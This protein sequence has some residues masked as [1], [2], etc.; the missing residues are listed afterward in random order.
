[1][2]NIDKTVE[3]IYSG[4]LG[5][6]I[7]V[8]YGAPIEGWTYEQ[9]QRV[10]G[11]LTIR[12]DLYYS[13]SMEELFIADDDTSMPSV[14]LQILLDKLKNRKPKISALEFGEGWLNYIP[15]DHGVIWRGRYGLS[16]EYTAFQNLHSG[17][18]APLSGSAEL[19]GRD[20]A[21]QIGGQIFSDIWGLLFPSDPERAANWADQ[22]SSVSHDLDG[23]IG[24]QFIAAMVSTA[25]GAETIDQVVELALAVLPPDAQYTL[26]MSDIRDFWKSHPENWH[27][28]RRYIAARYG[29]D[30]YPGPVPIIPNAAVIV[31]ALLYGQGDFDRSIRIANAAGWDTD[32]N[33]GN[34]G[35]IVGTLVGPQGIPAEWRKPLADRFVGSG[36]LGARNA[37]TIPGFSR[38]IHQVS[39]VL[40][41]DQVSES[42]PGAQ[43]SASLVEFATQ[44]LTFDFPGSTEGVQIDDLFDNAVIHIEQTEERAYAGNG[45]L[46]V[47]LKDLTASKPGRIVYPTLLRPV[48]F[49]RLQYDPSFSPVLYAGQAVRVEVYLPSEHALDN[50]SA[51]VSAGLLIRTLSARHD[52][53]RSTTIYSPFVELTPGAWTALEWMIPAVEGIITDVIIE[54]RSSH[55]YVS[56]SGPVY[57]DELRWF[58]NAHL[59]M[60]F[61]DAVSAFGAIE[62]WSYCSGYWRSEK[63]AYV[64]SGAELGETYTGNP[65]WRDVQISAVLRPESGFWHLV[66]A[67]VQGCR[68]SYGLGLGPDGQIVVVK[69]LDGKREVVAYSSYRWHTGIGYRVD[70]TVNETTIEL[71]VH[72]EGNSLHFQRVLWEDTSEEPLTRG[73]VGLAVRDGSRLACLDFQVNAVH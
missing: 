28:A 5:K 21:E 64:G 36:V 49:Y 55:N 32:C 27:A 26:V 65:E 61:D 11:D 23:R 9:I 10:Y 14:M 16:T 51:Q 38:L 2:E 33:T 6:V 25:F 1:M 18:P 39:Q 48:H 62:G 72:E 31:M 41:S 37:W 35:A 40:S 59:K 71:L 17:I 30:R 24:G 66:L 47:V 60:N 54:F 19:N 58:G 34:V 43:S 22:A 7:G 12:R 68:R 56:Y 44:R 52:S 63:G 42:K 46:K 15:R 29:Y 70:V 69:N 8:V 4:W 20:V 50:S 3:K 73:C 45:A 53:H 57:V 67:R 13:T